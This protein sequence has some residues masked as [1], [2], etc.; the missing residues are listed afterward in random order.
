MNIFWCC[1]SF[2]DNCNC[3]RVLSCWEVNLIHSLKSCSIYRFSYSFDLLRTSINLSISS[4]QH[5][6]PCYPHGMKMPPASF[7]IYLHNSVCTEFYI[8]VSVFYTIVFYC[9]ILFC[10]YTL[11]NIFLLLQIT[12]HFVLVN[13]KYLNKILWLLLMEH[14]KL[15]KRGLGM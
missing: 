6:C 9:H 15:W 3:F 1:W 5:P 4:D 7:T 10:N 14:N 8:L 2:D 12:A 11:L 13:E